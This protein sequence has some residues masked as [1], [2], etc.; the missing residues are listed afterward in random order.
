LKS[1]IRKTTVKL[2]PSPPTFNFFFAVTFVA[3]SYQVIQYICFEVCFKQ[4][5]RFFVMNGNYNL[6]ISFAA[7]LASIIVS[8]LSTIRLFIPIRTT[9]F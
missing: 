5:K 1:A 2:R 4:A 9:M 8:F 7:Y 6:P 3:E